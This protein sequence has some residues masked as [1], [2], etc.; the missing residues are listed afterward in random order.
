MSL[1]RGGTKRG[2]LFYSARE[3]NEADHLFHPRCSFDLIPL[4]VPMSLGFTSCLLSA[5][6]HIFEAFLS[7]VLR[8]L[9]NVGV[10]DGSVGERTY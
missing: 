9:R 7:V 3:G 1:D 5:K 2:A 8:L 10:V 4:H 6:L